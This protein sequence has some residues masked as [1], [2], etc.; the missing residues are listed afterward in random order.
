MALLELDQS[1]FRPQHQ[2]DMKVLLES[3]LPGMRVPRRE[4]YMAGGRWARQS[5]YQALFSLAKSILEDAEYYM[6]MNSHLQ[7][8]RHAIESEPIPLPREELQKRQKDLNEG[9]GDELQ[10]KLSEAIQ[11]ALHKIED[12]DAKGEKLLPTL[13]SNEKVAKRNR[14]YTETIYAYQIAFEACTHV[15]DLDTQSFSS[16]WFRMFY[17]RNYNALMIK[18]VYDNVIDNVDD[19]RYW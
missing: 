4:D 8:Y 11:I 16:T 6:A 3:W 2:L 19:V 18:S 13:L 12:A 15:H 10:S 5:Y 17:Q 7:R 9:D 1:S 14:L